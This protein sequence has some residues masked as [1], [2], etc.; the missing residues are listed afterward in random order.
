MLGGLP[1]GEDD[2]VEGLRLS[3][4]LITVSGSPFLPTAARS[5]PYT[6]AHVLLRNPLHHH[7]CQSKQTL[8]EDTEAPEASPCI[9][10][11]NRHTLFW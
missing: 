11:C 9:K 10:E 8:L 5:L 7:N 3:N 2:P 4:S 6:P 1:F